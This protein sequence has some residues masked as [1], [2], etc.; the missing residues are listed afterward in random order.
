MRFK[1]SEGLTESEKVLAELCDRSFLR[2]SRRGVRSCLASPK[3]N[4]PGADK[5]SMFQSWPMN[6]LV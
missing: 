4:I 3:T 6:C 5:Q 2:I 1:R